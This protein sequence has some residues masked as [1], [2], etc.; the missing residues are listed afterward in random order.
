VGSGGSDTGRDSTTPTGAAPAA[1]SPFGGSCSTSAHDVGG[2]TTAFQTVWAASAPSQ[3]A[4]ARLFVKAAIAS[5]TDPHNDY[6]DVLTFVVTA[7]Y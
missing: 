4:F 1:A 6:T 3:N 2:L 7:T 5:T